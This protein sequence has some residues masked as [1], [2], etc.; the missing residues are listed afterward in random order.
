MKQDRAAFVQF[1]KCSVQK[2]EALPTEIKRGVSSELLRSVNHRLQPLA[3]VVTH[4]RFQLAALRMCAPTMVVVDKAPDFFG[5]FV[6]HATF[7]HGSPIYY[8]HAVGITQIFVSWHLNVL[9][10]WR[11]IIVLMFIRIFLPSVAAEVS[12]GLGRVQTPLL[13]TYPAKLIMARGIAAGHLLNAA[14][15]EGVRRS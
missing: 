11:C 7:M 13:P 12:S 6:S 5:F 15:N 3:Y 4:T 14:G 8:P 1:R 9:W 10:V 2:A